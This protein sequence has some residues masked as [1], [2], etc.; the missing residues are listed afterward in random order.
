MPLASKVHLVGSVPL[1]SAEEVFTKTFQI[2]P[3]RLTRVP[4]GET[5]SRHYFT[6][7]QSF[8]F[9]PQVLSPFHRKGQPIERTEFKPI[10]GPPLESINFKPMIDH[11]KPTK[12][13]E[14]AINS[15][16]TFCRLRDEDVIPRKGVRFQV[17]VPTPLNTIHTHVDFAY[18]ERV[19]V[20]YME[21]LFQ[22]LK[23][24]QAIIPADDLAIQFDVAVELA[25]L[26]YERGRLRDPFFKPY[27]SSV[28]EGVVKRISELS[29]AINHDVQLGFH[30][31]YGDIQHEHFIQPENIGLLVEV[32]T[33]ILERVAHPVQ[34][35]HM[36]VPKN[37]SDEAYFEA[38]KGFDC[39]DT[40]LFLGVIHPHDERGSVKRLQA[41]HSAY[42]QDIGV[43]TECGMGR[44]PLG[45]IDSILTIS[46]N[47]T[48]SDIPA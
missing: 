4:D 1:S 23:N 40:E 47:I 2:L 6:L 24:L 28:K 13:D 18:R 39:G 45:D 25:Y 44:T 37:R 12:Y 22:D 21:R 7:W 38:L 48:S 29:S 34:W 32:A 30:L 36:P 15:Y 31:C 19:E 20:L 41:A 35:I 16:G 10:V 9:P 27:F 8:V 3:D 11:I 26:E 42:S 43:A 5:G 14:M 46:R 33:E 17:S